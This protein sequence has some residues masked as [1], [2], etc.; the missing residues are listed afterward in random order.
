ME[1]K[2][3]FNIIFIKY[4]II[5]L[6]IITTA[7]VS[8]NFYGKKTTVLLGGLPD[9]VDYKVDRGTKLFLEKTKYYD[10]RRSINNLSPGPHII[11]YDTNLATRYYAKINVKKGKNIIKPV[12]NYHSLPSLSIYR[13]YS[14]KYS[15]NI[16]NKKS[17]NYKTFSENGISNDNQL[18]IDINQEIVKKSDK[19]IYNFAWDIILNN[20]F[21]S[22]SHFTRS[23]QNKSNKTSFKQIIYKDSTHLYIAEYFF[24]KG[25]AKLKIWSDYL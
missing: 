25:T 4:I 10:L 15:N 21:I 8:I 19:Y 2:K 13:T 20:K 22:R 3:Q 24:V 12:F 18:E 17:F 5:I 16:N 9:N 1:F 23:D 6:I 11:H 14:N 7:I